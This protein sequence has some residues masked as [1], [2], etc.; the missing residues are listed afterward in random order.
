MRVVIV[1][2]TQINVTLL[3]HLVRKI[4]DCESVCFTASVAALAWCIDNEP[5]LLIVDYMM[6][7]LNG[8]E[9]VE[10]FRQIPRYADIPVMMVTANHD[11]EVRHHALQMGVTDFLHKPLDNRE[12]VTRASNLLELRKSHKQSFDPIESLTN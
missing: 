7:E 3:Q 8:I 5:D 12:F 11:A 6:P 4:P 1:D 2:D 9:L 10:R